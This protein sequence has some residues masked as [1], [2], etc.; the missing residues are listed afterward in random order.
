MIDPRLVEL[1]F[2]IRDGVADADELARAVALLRVA[3]GLPDE[4]RGV[5][6]D[7]DPT[8][9]ASSADGLLFVV[10]EVEGVLAEALRAEV[11]APAPRARFGV[12]RAWKR[13]FTERRG[14]PIWRGH[15]LGDAVRR[16]SGLDRRGE[17]AWDL[18]PAVLALV[19]PVS[20]GV[21]DE[22]VHEAL[23]AAVHAEAGPLEDRLLVDRVMM[24]IG[25]PLEVRIDRAIAEEAGRIDV[26]DAVMTA[27]GAPGLPLAAAIAAEGGRVD[28]VDA[29]LG[30]IG[31]PALPV[32]DAVR[33]AAGEVELVDDVMR[34]LGQS[35]VAAAVRFEAGPAPSVVDEVMARVR[36]TSLAPQ[37]SGWRAA[38]GGPWFAAVAAIAATVLAVIGFRPIDT[39]AP[40]VLQFADASEIVVDDLQYG[41]NATV[42]VLQAPDDALIIWVDEGTT[43]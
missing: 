18:T 9:R 10:G 27:V 37:A 34:A 12:G 3:D 15:R 43:L 4:L 11:T 35:R 28:V 1:L 19:A 38:N 17:P 6:D 7:P 41:D 13:R 22:L 42:Q 16:A 2:R 33:D 31:A 23:V 20:V 21:V 29:V 5:L 39:P 25:A 14:D 36:R 30:A 8:E 26:A 40:P 32:A 24:Q